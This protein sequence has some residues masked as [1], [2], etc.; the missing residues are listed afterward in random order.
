MQ[1]KSK[2]YLALTTAICGLFCGCYDGEIECYD[3][4]EYLIVNIL[5]ATNIDSAMI[6]INESQKCYLNEIR[7]Y[8]KLESEEFFYDEGVNKNV[9]DIERCDSVEKC[10]FWKSAGC[11]LGHSDKIDIDTNYISILLFDGSQEKIIN[12]DKPFSGRNIINIIPESDTA[13]WFGY[14]ENPIRPLFDVFDSPASSNRAGCYDGY[15]VATVPIV[16]EE[17][18][19]DK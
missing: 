19:Y 13:E 15:C 2:I 6:S 4:R 17:Y 3:S 18:C 5:S 14:K 12:I 1:K 7:L 9:T 8:A 11:I 10:F 16:E